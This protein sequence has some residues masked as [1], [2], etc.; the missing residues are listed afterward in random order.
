MGGCAQ[1]ALVTAGIC[2]LHVDFNVLLQGM[3]FEL[4]VTCCSEARCLLNVGGGPQ[5]VERTRYVGNQ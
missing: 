5:V 2:R 3:A 1:G 4:E